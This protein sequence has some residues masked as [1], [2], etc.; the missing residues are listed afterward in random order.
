MRRRTVLTTGT[1]VVSGTIAGCLGLGG[2]DGDEPEPTTTEEDA[3]TTQTTETG[4]ELSLSA[5]PSA[6][7]MEWGDEYSVEV[8][9]QSGEEP[10]QIVTGLMYQTEDDP[11]W[12]GPFG[13]SKM[14]WQLEAGETETKTCEAKPPSTGLLTVGLVNMQTKEVA[15]KWELTVQPPT[16]A[17]GETISYYDGLDM[18]LDAEVHES[19]DFEIE[20][21][22]YGEK[23]EDVFTVSVRN[24]KWV[25]VN[26]VAENTNEKG[27]VGLPEEG[28]FS[29]LA[30][31]TQ[32]DSDKPRS[33]GESVGEGSIY[34]I[35]EP[36]AD[37]DDPPWL[38]MHHDGVVQQD[39]YWY[40]PSELA[41]GAKEDG[42]I[43]YAVE[44]EDFTVDDVEVR[45]DRGGVDARAVWTNG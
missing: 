7:E 44:E 6:T 36:P 39:G 21:G 5:D 2:G 45:L 26:V 1:V 24:G 43:V 8:T 12:A 42:W 22:P 17:F 30:G 10:T 32:L 20:Y 27:E 16:A 13:N 35:A 11:N 31:N 19:M 25:K 40:P 34:E 38:E 4:G 3:Q 29:G 23:V 41:A 28:Q 9:V 14:M 37:E 15:A 18:T 33:L